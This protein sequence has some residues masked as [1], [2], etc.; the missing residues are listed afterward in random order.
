MF[1]WNSLPFSMI[2]WMF[3]SFSKSNL[4]IWKFSVHILLNPL[5]D[6]FEHYFA[7]IW[8]ECNCAVVWTFFGIAILWDWDEKRPFPVCGHCWLCWSQICWHI[9]CNTLTLSSF[10]IC[11][12]LTG[13]SSP[14][15][16]LF[17]V[18]L[19]KAHLTLHS[20]MSGSRWVIKPSC[21]SGSL[22]SF[23]FVSVQFSRS[24]VSDSLWPHESQ[25][26]RPPCPSPAP[27]VHSDS[28]PSS[29]WCH[30]PSHPLSSPFPPA[31]NPSQHQSLFQWFN[32]SHEVAKV[33]EFQL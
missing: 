25:H 30:P 32:S 12:S 20:R 11:N 15:L 21:L 16:A 27:A 1:F 23:F 26:T 13:I 24:V 5:L 17:L 6:N 28:R 31:P 33:L 9:K 19:P 4:N 7:N 10:R 3:L 29:Q 8:D 18:M 2:Q 22:R 14:P